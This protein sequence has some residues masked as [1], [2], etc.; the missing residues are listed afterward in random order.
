MGNIFE[1]FDEDAGSTRIW[2]FAPWRYC[3]GSEARRLRGLDPFFDFSKLV[4]M[5]VVLPAVLMVGSENL[6]DEKYGWRGPRVCKWRGG[7]AAVGDPHRRRY[8]RR[9]AGEAAVYGAVPGQAAIGSVAGCGNWAV[10]RQTSGGCVL[11]AVYQQGRCGSSWNRIRGQLYDGA[12]HRVDAGHTGHLKNKG[13]GNEG[14][15]NPGRTSR[16][17]C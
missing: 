10:L 11:F 1:R 17:G 7:A 4:A 14:P 15:R 12:Q 5:V 9:C 6:F 16:V 3:R 8:Q 2:S 13:Q